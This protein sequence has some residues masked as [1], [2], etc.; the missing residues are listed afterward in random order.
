MQRRRW[1]WRR[2]RRMRAKRVR[3]RR[4]KMRRNG[5]RKMRNKMA[6]RATT[7]C[8]MPVAAWFYCI[9]MDINYL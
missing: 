9:C 4:R 2:K 1:R 3:R 6:V 5:E 7:M 8:G